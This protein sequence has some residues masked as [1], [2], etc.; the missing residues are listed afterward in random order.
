M[1][2]AARQL[3]RL[4]QKLRPGRHLHFGQLPVRFPFLSCQ[5]AC[6]DVSSN[7]DNCGGCG[8]SCGQGNACQSGQCAC[9]PSLTKCEGS[10]V[11]LKSDENNCGQCGNQCDN[12]QQCKGGDCKGG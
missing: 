5:G 9:S 7:P 1:C 4:R 8:K 6:V 11:D 10:C 2:R 3:R 12:D